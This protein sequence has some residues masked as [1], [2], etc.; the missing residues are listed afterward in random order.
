MI[1]KSKSATF[2]TNNASFAPTLKRI[3]ASNTENHQKH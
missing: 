3:S 2:N 1:N